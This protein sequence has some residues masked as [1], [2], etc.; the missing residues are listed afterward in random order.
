MYTHVHT[1]THIYTHYTHTCTPPHTHPGDQ[2][3]LKI[4]DMR[5]LPSP[6]RPPEPWALLRGHAGCVWTASVLKAPSAPD[7]VVVTVCQ[8]RTV[9]L[10][11]SPALKE[12]SKESVDSI[13]IIRPSSSL[14]QSDWSLLSLAVDTRGRVAMAGSW[15]A[16]ADLGLNLVTVVDTEATGKE[17]IPGAGMADEDPFLRDLL[18]KADEDE[19]GQDEHEHGH[20]H[21]HGHGHGG[22]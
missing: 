22:C 18:E 13:A 6:S 19:Q 11:E 8:D 20:A 10:W 15:Q 4:W 5:Q 9:R 17:P 12:E 3:Q 2:D 16:G 21:A 1:C 14:L 7:P